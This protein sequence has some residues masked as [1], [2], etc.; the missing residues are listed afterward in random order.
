MAARGQ[1]G[2]AEFRRSTKTGQKTGGLSGSLGRTSSMP[3][4]MNKG[5]SSKN[6]V[7]PAV[8]LGPGFKNR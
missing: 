2:D 7:K 4:G 8:R 5:K 3:A 1:G 6:P